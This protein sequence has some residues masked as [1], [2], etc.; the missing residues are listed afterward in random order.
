MTDIIK[1][2]RKQMGFTQGELAKMCG[3]TWTTISNLERGVN[4]NHGLLQK[5]CEILGLKV[6]ITDIKPI[7][8]EKKEKKNTRV[9]S[10]D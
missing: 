4:V 3:C 7:E 5:V 2:K 10:I 8:V 9:L 1:K 6:E